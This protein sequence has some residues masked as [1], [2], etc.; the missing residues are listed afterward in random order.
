M[1]VP[2]I[3][4]LNRRIAEAGAGWI[5]AETP[6]SG[7]YGVTDST[8]ALGLALRPDDVLQDLLA[9]RLNESMSFA[10]APALPASIDW[11]NNGGNFVTPV[12]D[13]R[14]CGACVAFATAATIESRILIAQNRPGVDFDL[15]EAALFFCGAG[16]A[17]NLGWQPQAA[18]AHAQGHGLGRESAFPYT[19]ANQPC[20]NV[21]AVVNTGNPAAAAT[22]M[23]R[24]QAL[25]DGPAIAC[26]AVYGDFFSYGSG[27]YR[28][29]DGPLA[30][31]HAICVVGYDDGQGCWIVKNSWNTR[32]G[33]QGFFRIAYGEC[34]FDSQFPFYF[35]NSVALVPGTSIP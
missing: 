34:G 21:T 2:D 19:P 24:K 22:I 10:A 1:P 7:C 35:P 12:R 6:Y 26:M 13:Q 23:A 17:C 3:E 28:H 11:R 31:Y 5:A 32:W 15:S 4:A 18:L 27:I 16:Q 29:V 9:A 8:E 25:I 20:M 33:E 14:Q 30:G